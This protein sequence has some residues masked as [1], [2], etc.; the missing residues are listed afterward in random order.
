[1]E[2][3]TRMARNIPTKPKSITAVISPNT[4]MQFESDQVSQVLDN[5]N[6]LFSYNVTRHVDIWRRRHA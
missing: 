1:M 4:V 6:L 5:C 3:L 2:K